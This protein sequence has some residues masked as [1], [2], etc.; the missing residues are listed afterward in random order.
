[1]VV[2]DK[3]TALHC[4][5]NKVAISYCSVIAY[6]AMTFVLSKP[7]TWIDSIA[8]SQTILK[9]EK[10]KNIFKKLLI[11]L[12][13][14]RLQG[15]TWVDTKILIFIHHTIIFTYII[16]YIYILIFIVHNQLKF[17]FCWQSHQTMSI[18]VWQNYS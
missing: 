3:K 6:V 17:S 4:W 18:F 14:R 12:F 8:V 9:A 10:M 7:Y 5:I 2:P 1:M 11:E 16:I 15:R 13:L